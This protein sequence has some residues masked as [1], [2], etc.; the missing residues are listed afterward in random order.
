MHPFMYMV[1]AY[2]TG[3]MV[4]DDSGDSS[5]SYG[6]IAGGISGAVAVLTFIV[7]CMSLL[8]TIICKR[9]S[10]QQVTTVGTQQAHIEIEES[11]FMGNGSAP[12][13]QVNARY[14]ASPVM[15]ASIITDAPPT[16]ETVETQNFTEPNEEFYSWYESRKALWHRWKASGVSWN[17]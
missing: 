6:A 10:S 9:K 8:F 7:I 12:P 5:T 14:I 2:Y 15:G 13:L 17:C 3:S 1:A 11:S 4:D 16:Y